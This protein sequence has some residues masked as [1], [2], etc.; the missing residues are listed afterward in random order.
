[1]QR[2]SCA[3]HLTTTATTHSTRGWTLI[4][5]FQVDEG[6]T[7]TTVVYNQADVG[8]L[9][10]GYDASFQPKIPAPCSIVE[11]GY[12]G[13]VSNGADMLQFLLYVM[14]PNYRVL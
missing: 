4:Y 10:V 8:S 3:S 11:Y 5:F 7:P 9:P 2:T 13:I 6:S 12:G 1:V 14:S